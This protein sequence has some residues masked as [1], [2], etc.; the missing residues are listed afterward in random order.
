MTEY[1]RTH[2]DHLI[3]SFTD[4]SSEGGIIKALL[5]DVEAAMEAL[6]VFSEELNSPLAN[7]TLARL[8][9]WR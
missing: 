2:V 9:R 3:R 6:E 1:T 5:V 4:N 8:A 7:E